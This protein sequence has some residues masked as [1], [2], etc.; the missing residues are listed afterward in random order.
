QLGLPDEF[1]DHGDPAKLLAQCGLDAAGIA[2]SIRQ[3]F[4]AAGDPAAGDPAAGDPAAGTPMGA[5]ADAAANAA[6]V[7]PAADNAAPSDAAPS[8]AVG[9]VPGA[10]AGTEGGAKLV[11]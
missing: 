9:T 8:Q 3:R 4:P 11:A 5:A 10:A 1:I 2:A 7:T 6:A